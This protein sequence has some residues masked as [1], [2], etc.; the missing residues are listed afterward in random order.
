[1]SYCDCVYISVPG[2][3]PT[4]VLASVAKRGTG[5]LGLRL[6]FTTLDSSLL[7]WSEVLHGL[8]GTT[9]CGWV[10]SHRGWSV[11]PHHPELFFR[12]FM[13]CHPSL[14]KK[15]QQK[16]RHDHKLKLPL[17]LSNPRLFIQYIYEENSKLTRCQSSTAQVRQDGSGDLPGGQQRS[18]KTDVVQGFH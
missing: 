18:F 4:D 17:D 10:L 6:A 16:Q 14:Q 15:L 5:V 11:Q 1:M 7:A 13:P 9:I 12:G 2:L 8:F 3:I